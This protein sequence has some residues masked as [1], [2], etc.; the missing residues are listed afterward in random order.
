[1]YT[2]NGVQEL[3]CFLVFMPQMNKVQ[4]KSVRLPAVPIPRSSGMV[5]GSSAT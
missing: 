1:M 5:S 2:I 3:F 4:I